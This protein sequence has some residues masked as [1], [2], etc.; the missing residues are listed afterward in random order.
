MII[1]QKGSSMIHVHYVYMLNIT[2]SSYLL[3]YAHSASRQAFRPYRDKWAKEPSAFSGSLAR[4]WALPH[5]RK[6]LTSPLHEG[7]L[8]CSVGPIKVLKI[9]Y[10]LMDSYLLD[11][12]G[13]NEASGGYRTWNFDIKPTDGTTIFANLGKGGKFWI[14]YWVKLRRKDEKLNGSSKSLPLHHKFWFV[15]IWILNIKSKCFCKK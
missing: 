12:H 4:A 10:G 15:E 14:G 6:A 3:W 1:N 2:Q 13:L 7:S 9:R 11:I 5:S 8:K